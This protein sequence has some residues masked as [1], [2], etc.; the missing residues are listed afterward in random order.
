M[1][2]WKKRVLLILVLLLGLPVVAVFALAVAAR[3]FYPWPEPPPGV[4]LT[5][6]YPAIPKSELKPDNA[7]FYLMQ[8]KSG[9]VNLAFEEEEKIV[10]GPHPFDLAQHPNMKVM[11]EEAQ[12]SLQLLRQAAAAKTARMPII[13]PAEIIIKFTAY[14]QTIECLNRQIGILAMQGK[15]DEAAELAPLGLSANSTLCHGGALIHRL[16][17]IAGDS[18]ISQ[19]I[20]WATEMNTPS[21]EWLRRE[22]AAL[23]KAGAEAVPFNDTL[24]NDAFFSRHIAEL[25]YGE[26]M[27]ADLEKI[28]FAD[29]S[30]KSAWSLLQNLHRLHLLPI[31]NSSPKLTERHLKNCTVAMLVEWESLPPQKQLPEVDTD[32][33]KE[34]K[35]QWLRTLNDPVGHLDMSS[36]K[37]SPQDPRTEGMRYYRLAHLRDLNCLVSLRGTSLILALRLHQ[38]EHGEK[39]PATLAELVAA[40]CLDKLPDDPFAPPGTGFGYRVNP[41]GSFVIWSRGKNLKDDGGQYDPAKPGLGTNNADIVFASTETRDRRAKW[42]KEHPE[43][44]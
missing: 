15:W 13:E 20:R 30:P 6:L 2:K 11:Q 10:L 3:I 29:P 19:S 5:P 40:K 8:L 21:P 42:Q 22:M 16:I 7:V 38:L 35:G 39:L 44:K 1:A 14:R 34:T 4:N 37:L 43:R 9:K 24:R 26:A 28:W 36:G 31:F 25:Y 27:S 32:T 33:K 12:P 18:M 23:T 41:D 17:A